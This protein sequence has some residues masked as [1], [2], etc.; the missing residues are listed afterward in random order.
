MIQD[1]QEVCQESEAKISSCQKLLEDIGHVAS[2]DG[3]LKSGVHQLSW[4]PVIYD[5]FFIYPRW[6]SR[7]ISE[8]STVSSGVVPSHLGLLLG[9]FKR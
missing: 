8:P 2:V 6:F 5:G 7:R 4:N 1:L 3:S 9:F